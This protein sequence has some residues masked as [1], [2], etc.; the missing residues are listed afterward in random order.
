MTVF[1]LTK[2][3]FVKISRP[4]SPTAKGKKVIFIFKFQ[5][6]NNFNIWQ[7]RQKDKV[8]R[9]ETPDEWNMDKW[10]ES[11]RLDIWQS[12]SSL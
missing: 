10:D 7:K 6:Q 3:I 1:L 4:L 8:K 11:D 2:L 5:S 12:P 9:K